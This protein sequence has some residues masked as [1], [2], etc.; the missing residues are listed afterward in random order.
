MRFRSSTLRSYLLLGTLVIVLLF[1]VNRKYYVDK[2]DKQIPPANEVKK[3]KPFVLPPAELFLKK[4]HT[5]VDTLEELPVD[6]EN[7]EDQNKPPVKSKE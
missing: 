2:V 7:G 6:D 3:Q 4:D 1:V 5:P